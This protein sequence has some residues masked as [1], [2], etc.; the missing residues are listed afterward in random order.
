MMIPNIIKIRVDEPFSIIDG[1]TPSLIVYEFGDPR[2]YSEGYR[3]RILKIMKSIE[4]KVQIPRRQERHHAQNDNPTVDD[5]FDEF[6]YLN[7][8]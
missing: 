1:K 6:D 2:I 4:S 5:D 3:R 7:N 8:D